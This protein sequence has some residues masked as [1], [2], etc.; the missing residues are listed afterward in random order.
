MALGFV[1]PSFV[2]LHISVISDN[3]GSPSLLTIVSGRFLSHWSMVM[4]SK[5]LVVWVLGSQRP[6]INATV[7]MT[8]MYHGI[9]F[10]L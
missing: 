2:S 1:S 9:F 4:P 6:S 7:H 3:V 8:L 10:H 5:A